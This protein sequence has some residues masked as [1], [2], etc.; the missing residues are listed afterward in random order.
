MP[1]A[2]APDPTDPAREE[3]P[4]RAAPRLPARSILRVESLSK[5]FPGTKA[6][7]DVSID[8]KAGQAH[9][10]V[11]H[12]GSGKSTLIKVLSGYHAR[13]GRPGVARWSSQSM[14]PP[15][16]TGGHGARGAGLSFVHQD[17]GLVLELNTMDN[18]ALHG[19]FNKGRFGRVHWKEQARQA[20]RLLEPF[21]LELDITTP[22]SKATPVERTIVAI[23][24]ALQGWS[25]AGGVLVLDEPTAVLPP[26]EV[27]RLFKIVRDLKARGPASST[28]SHRLDEIFELCEEVTVLRNGELVACEPVAGLTEGPAR[29]PDA[30][31]RDGAGLPGA[32]SPRRPATSRC[33]TWLAWPAPTSG[34]RRSRSTRA[35]CSASPACPTRTRRAATPAHRSARARQ[36]RGSCGSAP[37]RSGSRSRSGRRR[38]SPCCRRIGAEKGIV[39]PMTVR[40]NMSISVLDEFGPPY[41]LSHRKEKKFVADWMGKLD[42]VAGG[43]DSPIQTLS[44]GNQQ[45]VLFGRCSAR[46]PRVL[47]LCEPTAGVDIGARHAIYELVAEQ[48]RRGL[49]VLVASSDVG[50]LLALCTRVLVLQH[51][52][53]AS[54]LQG[55]GLTEHRLVQAMEGLESEPA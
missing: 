38:P 55:A 39:G 27:G 33:S 44:G 2:G 3:H 35:R 46:E 31:R 53:V 5:T 18:L 12:N 24:A 25:D 21:G 29:A 6:L 42:V 1:E 47:V 36:R 48:V 10:L 15:S 32:R 26:G 30:R 16:A 19:G 17:L 34:T 7:S 14:S 13:P 45:K 9:A 8:V 4:V 52:V 43:G 28:C 41:W 37:T 40:E 11:G 54:E 20:R 22:L 23:A 50:D 49:S 51:G